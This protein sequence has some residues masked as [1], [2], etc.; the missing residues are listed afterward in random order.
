M[1]P[2][3][4]TYEGFPG[5]S[6]AEMRKLQAVSWGCHSARSVLLST[7]SKGASPL[8]HEV[9]ALCLLF[10][11]GFGYMLSFLSGRKG[12]WGDGYNQSDRAFERGKSNSGSFMKKR[13][14]SWVAIKLR[15]HSPAQNYFWFLFKCSK[16]SGSPLTGNQIS[17]NRDLPQQENA[18]AFIYKELILPN[19]GERQTQWQTPFPFPNGC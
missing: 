8:A 3:D 13:W 11:P 16:S 5:S 4:P 17:D 2:S 10:L 12:T 1:L 7:S 19:K 6:S 14:L 9:F 15:V 18:Q